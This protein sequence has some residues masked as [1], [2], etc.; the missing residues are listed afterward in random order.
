MGIII[1]GMDFLSHYDLLV[2]PRNR[3]L[4]DLETNLSTSGYVAN[5]NIPSVKTIIA[6][7][8]YHQLFARYPEL[9]RSPGF[10]KATVKHRVRH[11]IKTTPGPPVYSKPRCLAPDRYR[12]VKAEFDLMIKLGIIRPSKSPWSSPLYVVPKEN[13]TLRPCRDYRVLNAGTVPD[14][15]TP[16]HV[17]DILKK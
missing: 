3:R 9:T 10:G 8:V 4:I 6:D 14:R 1:I 16:A 17:E 11:H 13:G 5:T 15:Y 7:S 12:Q 2:D